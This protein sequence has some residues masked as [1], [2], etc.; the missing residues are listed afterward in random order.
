MGMNGT[1]E[2]ITYE[3]VAAYQAQVNTYNTNSTGTQTGSYWVNW[4]IDNGF[5]GVGW[6]LENNDVNSPAY[7]VNISDIEAD[8]S[9]GNLNTLFSNWASKVSLGDRLIWI[10]QLSNA[11]PGCVTEVES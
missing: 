3:E 8:A 4:D 6:T 5:T 9:D 10:G 1:Q 2:A 11:N 7:G